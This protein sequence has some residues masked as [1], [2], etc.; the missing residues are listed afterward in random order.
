[1]PDANPLLDFLGVVGLCL[2]CALW[3]WYER[4]CTKTVGERTRPLRWED[5]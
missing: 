5:E 2:I 4:Q 1:M 3:G